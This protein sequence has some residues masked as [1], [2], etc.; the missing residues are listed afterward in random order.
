MDRRSFL[1]GMFAAA[2]YV[3]AVGTFA[4]ADE[5]Y[6]RS[7]RMYNTHTGED[8]AV[9][10]RDDTGYIP[11]ALE[12]INHFL[13]CHH[14]NEVHR[15]EPGLIDLAGRIDAR[16]GGGNIIQVISG[17]HSPEYNSILANRSSSVAKSSLHMK[18]LALDFTIPGIR[19]S[20]LFKSVR[21]MN[22]GG[23]GLYTEFVHMDTGRVRSWGSV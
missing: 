11:G 4:E 20:D 14:T 1:K 12:E 5:G 7:V 2:L 8:I 10:Y 18:G 6:P 17:Y 9:T 3:G 21:S 19:N 16:Y 13:R 15:I 22:A 23:A